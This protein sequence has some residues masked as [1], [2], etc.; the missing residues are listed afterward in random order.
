MEL[1]PLVLRWR[2]E[3]EQRGIQQGQ[4]IVGNNLLR[5]RF[6]TLDEQLSPIIEYSLKL[7]QEEFILLL[8]Q[9]LREKLLPKFGKQTL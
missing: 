4:R 5:F 3:A 9:S 8:L 6:T 1:S 2:E 7:S